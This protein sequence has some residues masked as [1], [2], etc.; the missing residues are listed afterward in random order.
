MLKLLPTPKKITEEE[1]ILSKKSVKYECIDLD[2]RVVNALKKLPC[3]A[4]GIELKI[5]ISDEASE[6]YTLKVTNEEIL[7][8]AKSDA[9]AF[10][11]VQTLRQIFENEVVPC[12]YIEDEP[13]F[14]YRGFYQD[15]TRGKV[16]KLESLKKLIDDMAYHKLN[17]LQIYIEHAFEFKEFA[18]SIERTGYMTADEIRELDKYCID[19]FIE[20]IPSLATFGHLYELLEKDRYK[21]LASIDNFEANEHMW[22]NRQKHH[23]LEPT[24]PESFELAKSLIDQY[25]PLFNSERFNICCDEPFD[26][27][28]GR[29]AG[30]DTMKLYVDYVSKVIRYVQSK[31]KKVQ[32]WGSVLAQGTVKT[33]MTDVK[34]T[35]TVPSDFPQGVELMLANYTTDVP[36]D[37]F[38]HIV[39]QN[40]PLIVIPGISAWCRYIEKP[41][42]SEKNISIMARHAKKF[43]AL[44]IM[45]TNWGDYGHPCSM[46]LSMY[47]FAMGAEKCWNEATEFDDKFAEA[48]DLHIYAKEG[49]TALVKK[50]A[51][52]Y[53]NIGWTGLVMY[54]SDQIYKNKFNIGVQSEELLKRV[55][56]E[57]LA[58]IDEIGTEKWER[59]EFRQELIICA[60]VICLMV[61]LWCKI[62]NYPIERKIDTRKWVEKYSQKWLEKNKPSEL[63]EIQKVFLY[64]EDM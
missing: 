52:V 8:N 50:L 14:E 17:K 11:A 64:L 23:T 59:D 32:M 57:S 58:V 13:D 28:H 60:E 16:P 22:H 63:A 61:E 48:V 51:G 18:D 49:A 1:N 9:A 43:D 55:H 62:G 41:S 4:D 31:G 20:F 26:L 29:H 7:I 24:N 45:N 39:E 19:N 10:Y 47:G 30:E 46:E 36:E 5:E 53:D 56:A 3:S 42:V 40:R 21:H 6:A 27:A 54:Y 34:Y 35:G 44:G 25:M 15:V 33:V 12:C 2:Y 38:R 37:P